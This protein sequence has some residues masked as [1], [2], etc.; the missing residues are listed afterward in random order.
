MLVE[1]RT[2]NFKSIRDDL[3][4]SLVAGSDKEKREKNTFPSG[5]A[6]GTDLLRS[7]AIYGPNASGK[8]ALVGAMQYA[9]AMVL[10]SASAMPGQLLNHYPFKLDSDSQASPSE[11][12]FTFVIDGTRYQYGFA[13]DSTGV[14]EEWLL[15]YQT[16]KAQAW[17]ER[18]FDSQANVDTFKF[19]A[20]LTGKK[21]VW[22]E[23][24]RRNTLFLSIAAQFNSDILL[25]V[26]E[27]ISRDL[28]IFSSSMPPTMEQSTAWISDASA[29]SL[30][31]DFLTSADIG[32]S[33]LDVRVRE[34]HRSNLEARS[35]LPDQ[36]FSESKASFP[37]FIHTG[38]DG[39]VALEHEEESAGTRRLFAFA[40][41][42]IES[43]Q[44]GNTI[45]VDELDASLHTHIVQFLVGLFHHRPPQ[46]DRAAQLIF[47]THD[48][49]LLDAS[50]FRRD[51]IWLME[52][53]QSH[54][55]TLVPLT[56]FSPR[57]HEAVGRG[58]LQGR[59]GALP[60]TS[61]FSVEGTDLGS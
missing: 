61:A 20:A 17:F 59:Y 41:P 7:A 40:A 55:S 50:I 52:K 39:Q 33:D 13:V 5:P 21:R 9:Q 42:W 29:K 60:V 28:V 45:V 19:G 22:Q 56:D 36:V 57:K 30:L 34:Q 44:Q 18:S 31:L 25:P 48:T 38:P 47:T 35:S 26:Y 14:A 10:T 12:E 2:K 53:D 51:Q 6:S 23:A 16:H 58:Y 11:F 43:L 27:W 4:L 32:I 24:T 15:V 49:A 37:V 46:G 3:C 8:S 54:A 1:F